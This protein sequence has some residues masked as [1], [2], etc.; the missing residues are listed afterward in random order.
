MS[1]TPETAQLPPRPVTY[2]GTGALGGHRLSAGLITLIIAAVVVVASVVTAALVLPGHHHSK[3]TVAN[4]PDTAGQIGPPTRQ[5]IS[6]GPANVVPPPEGLEIGGIPIVLHPDW[7]VLNQFGSR[8]D[9]RDKDDTAVL[10]IQVENLDMSDWK[11]VKEIF[12][13]WADMR[14]GDRSNVQINPDPP[15]KI[16]SER[17]QSV[18]GAQ[19]S[20]DLSTQGGTTTVYGVLMVMLNPSSGQTLEVDFLTDSIDDFNAKWP[21]AKTIIESMVWP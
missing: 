19:Y 15:K 17:F 8:V 13:A 3:P 6:G 5:P 4:Q 11:N 1:S 9:L 21:Q 7:E 12:S 14:S 2:P 16:D 18:Q 10:M 20:A